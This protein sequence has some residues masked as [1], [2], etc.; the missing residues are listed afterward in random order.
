[1][2][3]LF[4]S[5]LLGLIT[6][7]A[8]AKNKGIAV[9]AEPFLKVQNP[10][11]NVP[12]LG[13]EGTPPKDI[14]PR[15][16]TVGPFGPTDGRGAGGLYIQPET[17]REERIPGL[18]G[19]IPVSE[20]SLEDMHGVEG[21]CYTAATPSDRTAVLLLYG[22]YGLVDA[23]AVVSDVAF[24][25]QPSLC[26]R[27]SRVHAGLATLSGI[28][29]GMSR[30]QVRAILGRPMAA[31]SW[32]DGIESVKWEPLTPALTH[33]LGWDS[34]TTHRTRL[35]QV[36]VWYEKDRVVG[37]EVEEFSQEGPSPSLMGANGTRNE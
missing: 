20:P 11:R 37:F 33:K 28:R 25:R 5:L 13:K 24:I 16:L 18:F 2:P 9:T 30:A 1:M 34:S 10:D 26:A 15:H 7:E 3:L 14:D 8:L 21:W 17:M 29:L 36:V 31:D 22:V 23:I 6:G 32:R 19:K 4:A 35:Q 27:T 12:P